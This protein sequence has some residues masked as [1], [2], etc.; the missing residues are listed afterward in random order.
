MLLWRT[1][2]LTVLI[3]EE[4][5]SALEV[6]KDP[7]AGFQSMRT[8][9]HSLHIVRHFLGSRCPHF[10]S[11]WTL[12]CLIYDK[13][14]LSCFHIA[15]QQ[16]TLLKQNETSLTIQYVPRPG[17]SGY[18]LTARNPNSGATMVDCSPTACEIGNLPP[19]TAFTLWLRTCLREYWLVCDLEALPYDTFTLPMRTLRWNLLLRS[20]GYL[21]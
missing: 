17:I 5:T 18:S 16:L 15:T 13:P 1:A 3:L 6:I 14:F 11:P 21:C 20:C 4:T 10:R 7:S 8:R 9:T 12:L 19:G 2:R